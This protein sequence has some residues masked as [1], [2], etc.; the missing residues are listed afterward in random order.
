[1]ADNSPHCDAS[2]QRIFSSAGNDRIKSWDL[3]A[4]RR[5]RREDAAKEAKHRGRPLSGVGEEWRILIK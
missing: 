3:I 2:Q 1:M 5:L 4:K